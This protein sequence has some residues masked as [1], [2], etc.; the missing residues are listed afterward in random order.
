MNNFWINVNKFLGK[1][2]NDNDNNINKTNIK[3]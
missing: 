1:I 3:L 2:S